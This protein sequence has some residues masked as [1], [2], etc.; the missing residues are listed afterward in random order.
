MNAA[1]S[2]FGNSNSPQ[3]I[4]YASRGQKVTWGTRTR[5]GDL[6]FSGLRTL[7]E[8]RRLKAAWDEEFPDYAPYSITRNGR[9]YH[10]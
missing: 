2:I 9:I 6:C 8:A 7:K 3:P 1:S 4:A 5:Y 10:D